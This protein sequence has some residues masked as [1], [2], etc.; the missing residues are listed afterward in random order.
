[1]GRAALPLC[2]TR[3]A[4]SLS[5][6]QR[7]GARLAEGGPAGRSK[8][9]FHYRIFGL[10]GPSCRRTGRQSVEVRGQIFV[11]R[12]LE[13]ASNLVREDAFRR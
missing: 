5:W 6:F 1:M 9:L 12:V 7:L 11:P 13:H 3:H 2:R 10:R 4:I 8:G